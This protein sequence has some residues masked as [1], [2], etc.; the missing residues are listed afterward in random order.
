LNYARRKINGADQMRKLRLPP[1]DRLV[2]TFHFYEPL[3]FTH[4]KAPWVPETYEYGQTVEYPAPSPDLTDFLAQLPQ[5]CTRLK[6]F[7]G[8]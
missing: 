8:K 3:I 1:D 2:Y 6:R 5:H 7:L 4:Q